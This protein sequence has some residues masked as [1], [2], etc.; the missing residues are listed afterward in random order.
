MNL[1]A[2]LF[3][4]LLL[5]PFV[6][7]AVYLPQPST[8][9]GQASKF[10]V[11]AP[12]DFNEMKLKFT[13]RTC[14]DNTVCGFVRG[15]CSKNLPT[16]YGN[17]FSWTGS[18]GR[19]FVCK[20]GA[21]DFKQLP[22]D[23]VDYS[24]Y[25]PVLR[26][27]K[28]GSYEFSFS[29][30]DE[31]WG[32]NSPASM[33]S[34]ADEYDFKV[35]YLISQASQVTLSKPVEFAVNVS[36]DAGLATTCTF[37]TLQ[38]L[39]ANAFDIRVFDQMGGGSVS[40]SNSDGASFPCNF[41]N[42][43]YTISF[44]T[45]PPYLEVFPF[46]QDLSKNSS[47]S[48]Q[49]FKQVQRIVN[50]D[51][52][53][54]LNVSAGLRCSENIFGFNCIKH[55]LFDLR[56][57]GFEQVALHF[58][59]SVL[60]SAYFFDGSDIY[61]NLSNPLPFQMSDVFVEIPNDFGFFSLFILEN[62]AWVNVTPNNSFKFSSDFD[63]IAFKI[64]AILSNS[65]VQFKLNLLPSAY[66]L[67]VF[68]LMQSKGFT[69]TFSEQVFSQ[70]QQVYNPLNKS[71]LAMGFL[72]CERGFKCIN[73]SFKAQL[74]PFEQK[75]FTLI[76]TG[77]FL[78]ETFDGTGLEGDGKLLKVNNS[79]MGLANVVFTFDAGGLAWEVYSNPTLKIHSIAK[80]Y[81]NV[82]VLFP[83]IAVG[84]SFF[85]FVGIKS[86]NGVY[87][88]YDS[89]CVSSYCLHGVCRDGYSIISAS[90][91]NSSNLIRGNST[92]LG[93]FE[94]PAADF[95]SPS[96]EGLLDV[97]FEV[98]LGLDS[99]ELLLNGLPYE[100]EVILE[101]PSGVVSKVSVRGG[102]LNYVFDELGTWKVTAGG[103]V[104]KFFVKKRNDFGASDADFIS[105]LDSIGE[106]PG[107]ALG[108]F[109]M[110]AKYVESLLVGNLFVIPLSLFFILLGLLKISKPGFSK[111]VDSKNGLVKLFFRNNAGDLT[112]VEIIDLVPQG[113]SVSSPGLFVEVDTIF[114]RALI[115]KYAT[116]RK[117]E[118]VSLEYALGQSPKNSGPA[119]LCALNKQGERVIIESKMK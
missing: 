46:A 42:G 104:S 82:T 118:Q 81:G 14:G 64:P 43:N 20:Y 116:L 23:C 37:S 106:N 19:G 79:I 68:G 88:K 41:S 72:K 75:N 7:A 93:H 26:D 69:S 74:K 76:L 100:G 89:E 59:A 102:I 95:S 66:N 115:V 73:S 87:C 49:F 27:G 21:T 50:N 119:K 12:F 63:K 54:F 94:S 114:G 35:N 31:V 85:K 45:A 30:F 47:S 15:H 3:S 83:L 117:G 38:G 78:D 16:V 113:C 1:L 53:L 28:K 62:N 110:V 91:L 90:R 40:I 13:V 101:S 11:S 36:A 5:Q 57:Y 55:S 25:G 48:L 51:S 9:C 108:N 111:V 2:L 10:I 67:T 52:I 77:D 33:V 84:E 80:S 29:A 56:P 17:G 70:I 22:S 6:F 58:N 39:P 98:Q 24:F 105:R 71:V 97:P 86:F 96:S 34:L 18:G 112:G 32:V 103:A 61:Y 107:L 4:F 92:G 44:S 65:T 99:F 109:A 8:S 60:Q